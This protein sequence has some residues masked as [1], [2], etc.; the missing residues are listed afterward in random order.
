MS[1][2]RSWVSQ[3]WIPSLKVGGVALTMVIDSKATGIATFVLLISAAIPTFGNAE[4]WTAITRVAAALAIGF[5]ILGMIFRR[6]EKRAFWTG[7]VL[8]GAGS[9]LVLGCGSGEFEVRLLTTRMLDWVTERA[10]PPVRVYRII[11]PQGCPRDSPTRVEAEKLLAAYRSDPSSGSHESSSSGVV[12][13][14]D[15][16]AAIVAREEVFRTSV[17]LIVILLG[18]IGGRGARYFYEP[19]PNRSGSKH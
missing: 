9:A 3:P 4:V 8:F 15:S 7:F 19:D 13:M 16:S 12:E 11:N 18:C 10:L 17:A 1:P 14:S 5:G 2:I 6:G